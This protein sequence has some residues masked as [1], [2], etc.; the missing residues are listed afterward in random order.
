MQQK[1]CKHIDHSH[2][3][4][5]INHMFKGKP[6]FPSK[7]GELYNPYAH[8]HPHP[9]DMP[10]CHQPI[11][12]PNPKTW[13]FCRHWE[14]YR[15]FV[16]T[17]QFANGCPG[18]CSG[19]YHPDGPLNLGQANI[20]P[21][22]LT[23]VHTECQFSLRVTFNYSNKK[24]NTS[25][26]L[27]VGTI[28]NVVYLENGEIYRCTGKCSDIWKVYGTDNAVYYKIKFDCSVDYN[29]HT[30][31]I[32]NDQIRGLSVYTGY[33]NEDTSIENSEHSYGTTSGVLD[34][35]VITHA[36]M[37][38][39]GNFIDGTVI[40][41]TLTGYTCD[42]IAK[43]LNK[44]GHNIT[45]VHTITENGNLQNGKIISGRFISGSINGG[46]T[47]P[48][49][50]IKYDVEVHGKICHVIIINSSVKGGTSSE[51]TIITPEISDGIVYNAV[52]TG[53]DLVTTGGVTV[54]NITT[55]GTSIGGTGTGGTAVG[56]IDGQVYTIE[57]GTTEPE[58][59]KSLVTSGGVVTG[60]A[61]VGGIQEGNLIIG[62]T[63]QGGV[64]TQGT[65]I[66]GVTKN[67]TF[68]PTPVNPLP[69][70][71]VVLQNENERDLYPD[72]HPK[73][74]KD[75][76]TGKPI[77]T[78]AHTTDATTTVNPGGDDYNLVIIQ[79]ENTAQTYTNFGKAVMQDI[80]LREIPDNKRHVT[81]K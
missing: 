74:R 63:I 71:K 28:Y 54:G 5:P 4:E 75:P 16:D 19:L 2:P 52:I 33:E 27:S 23:A 38:A 49:T 72:D 30:V 10:P 50:N 6:P 61:I 43:G 15:P 24:F 44:S 40:K 45:T 80:P 31:I 41:G 60:G 21:T 66:N 55:G 79:D 7:P 37:D 59:G 77:P 25:V 51:G 78:G 69:I 1:V 26:D 13:A 56:V 18:V 48:Q 46:Y 81:N 22:Y 20:N 8:M 9:H 70:G 42:G 12:H 73:T 47:D 36:T 53:S 57:E 14:Q 39:N 65:T 76:I 35:A 64:V 58:S 62:A 3:N 32:K 29:N 67:G 11:P 34:D 17:S 68:I